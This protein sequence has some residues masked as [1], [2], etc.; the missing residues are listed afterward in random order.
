[1][2]L[3]QKYTFAQNMKSQHSFHMDTDTVYGESGV[4]VWVGLASFQSN[5]LI[6]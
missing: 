5:K 4:P 1:M 3:R 2:F 6:C